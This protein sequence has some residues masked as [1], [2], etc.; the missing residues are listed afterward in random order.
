MTVRNPIAKYFVGAILAG[1][2]GIGCVA[3]A[4]AQTVTTTFN[5]QNSF[6]S[7]ITL[8]TVSCGPSA[9][10]SPPF[11]IPSGSSSGNFSASTTGG[12]LMCTVR[13]QSQNGV[14]GCQFQLTV[15]VVGGSTTGSPASNAYKGS[16]GHPTCPNNGGVTTTNQESAVFTM[17]P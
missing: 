6:G 9:S 13:Y 10:I 15:N 17:N 11:S 5:V 8:D 14:D 2:M 1:L 4:A 7:T 3:S 16:G 12:T